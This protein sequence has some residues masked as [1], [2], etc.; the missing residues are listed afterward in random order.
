MT[1]IVLKAQQRE[2]IG[3]KVRQ[4]RSEK[5]IPAVIYGQGIKNQNLSVGQKDLITVLS[6]AGTSGLVDLTIDDLKPVKI[7]IHDYQSDPLT[8]QV[9]HVDFYQIKEGQKITTDIP[10]E[11]VGEVTAVKE[12]GGIFVQ[13]ISEVEVECTAKELEIMQTIKV[14]LSVLKNI[15]DVIHVK[16]LIVPKGVKVLDNPDDVVAIVSAPQEE[17]VETA[18][19]I[20]AA[21][22]QEVGKD[23]KAEESAE[24]TAAP[25]KK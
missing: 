9:I 1:A 8:N 16:D 22:V 14:D 24:A 21:E 12:F 7:L 5:L 11:L 3:K 17:T 10:L 2:I 20:S 23:A 6:Q 4:V 19:A 15:N 13:N 25:N 18:P